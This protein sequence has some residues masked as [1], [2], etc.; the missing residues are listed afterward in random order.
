MGNRAVAS[1]P[2]PSQVYPLGVK[3]VGDVVNQPNSCQI[4]GT[5]IDVCYD[6]VRALRG[7]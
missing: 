2:P 5:T 7:W 6:P 1:K 3:N 4:L